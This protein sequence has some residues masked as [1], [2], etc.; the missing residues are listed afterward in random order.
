MNL[1]CYVDP[2]GSAKY[3]PLNLGC[4]YDEIIRLAW[5]GIGVWLALQELERAQRASCHVC[6]ECKEEDCE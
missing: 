2:G 3:I 4:T 5:L 6:H 1:F